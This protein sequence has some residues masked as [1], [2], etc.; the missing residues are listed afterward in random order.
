MYLI[1]RDAQYWNYVLHVFEDF[2]YKNLVPA[3]ELLIESDGMDIEG[4]EVSPGSL[5]NSNIVL[6][7]S[8]RN[9]DQE[10]FTRSPS[11]LRY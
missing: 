8:Y 3:R 9:I 4:V 2:W 1:E 10:A 6:N 11:L 7:Y 5:H